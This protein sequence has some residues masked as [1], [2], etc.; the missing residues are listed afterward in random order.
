M[1]AWVVPC[2]LGV[3]GEHITC[4]TFTSDLDRKGL[5]EVTQPPSNTPLNRNLPIFLMHTR[6]RKFTYSIKKAEHICF[7]SAPF[8]GEI[9]T[10]QRQEHHSGCECEFA[11]S[12][13]SQSFAHQIG[14]RDNKKR[15]NILSLVWKQTQR[16][17]DSW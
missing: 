2:L 12:P 9:C 5:L 10:E 1:K 11:Y 13:D 8:F 16:P 3:N 15:K 14:R 17:S 7:S 6:N 4:W